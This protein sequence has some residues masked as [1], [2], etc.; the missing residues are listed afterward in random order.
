MT[1]TS[2]N[3]RF[4]IIDQVIQEEGSNGSINN[5][6]LMLRTVFDHPKVPILIYTVGASILE[7]CA[8]KIFICKI[9]VE[10][11]SFLQ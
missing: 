7:I 4:V 9:N 11:F 5:D 10:R 1:R 6:K 8:K 2:S 3:Y